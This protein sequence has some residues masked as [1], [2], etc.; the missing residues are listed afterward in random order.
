MGGSAVVPRSLGEA[1]LTLQL[2]NWPGG[3]APV[4]A[5]LDRNSARK[6][7]REPSDSRAAGH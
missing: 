7:E 6:L 2:S 1:R 4:R 5:M 3:V